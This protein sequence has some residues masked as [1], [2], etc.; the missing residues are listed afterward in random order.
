MS[1]VGLLNFSELTNFIFT[2]KIRTT[3]DNNNVTNKQTNYT[4]KT[5]L[6]NIKSIWKLHK[7]NRFVGNVYS[8][9]FRYTIKYIQR[10]VVLQLLNKN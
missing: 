6:R 3:L 9:I 2:D 10:S 8:Y 5:Y 1:Y 7:Q 4:M